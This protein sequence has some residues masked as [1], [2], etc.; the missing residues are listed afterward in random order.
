[1]IYVGT[2]PLSLHTSALA[3]A[4]LCASAALTDCGIEMFDVPVACSV[5]GCVG[6]EDEEIGR[7]SFECYVIRL[8]EELSKFVKLFVR[9]RGTAITSVNY[10]VMLELYSGKSGL[11]L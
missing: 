2:T 6:P 4:V 5:V 1:M 9:D 7:R 3:A 8:L 11:V 10:P